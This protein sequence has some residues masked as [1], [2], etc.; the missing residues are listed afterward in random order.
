MTASL[1]ETACPEAG[2]A[3]ARKAALRVLLREKRAAVPEWT[4]A[5]YDRAI[6][7]RLADLLPESGDVFFYVGAGF[8]IATLDV[9][10]DRLCRGGGVCVPL[11]GRA[12]RMTARRIRRVTDLRPGRFG[13]PEPPAD[14]E[15]A[16]APVMAVVPGLAFSPAGDRI[17]W[18]GGYYDRWHAA[19]PACPA[20]GLCYE[21]FL[22][23][24]PRTCLDRRVGIILTERRSISCS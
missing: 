12:G 1:A 18:G 9:I 16:E 8:E 20:V 23:P 14:A 2:D 21:A 6:A 15:A 22:M 7:R 24:L 19:H 4:R 5:A 11:C 10:R 17:G 13:L 3:A